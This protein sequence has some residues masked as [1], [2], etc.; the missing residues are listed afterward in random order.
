MVGVWS[1]APLASSNA[2]M[3]VS[4]YETV[5]VRLGDSVWSIAAKYVTERDDIRDLTQAINQVN[6]LQKNGEI[7]PGQLLKIPMK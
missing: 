4:S 7:F 6:N 3:H 2:Y 1:M 5:Q